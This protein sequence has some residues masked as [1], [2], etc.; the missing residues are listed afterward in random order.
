MMFVQLNDF[1]RLTQLY[2]HVL[3]TSFQAITSFVHVFKDCFEKIMQIH[4]V[5][6][7]ST[8]LGRHVFCF[9]GSCALFTRPTKLFFQQN[10][11]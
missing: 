3:T 7:G 5:H 11:H 10:K 6:L 2:G 4:S 9:S 8:F 1:P